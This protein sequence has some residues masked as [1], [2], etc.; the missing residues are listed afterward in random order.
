MWYTESQCIT[1]ILQ[2]KTKKFRDLSKHVGPNTGKFKSQ[3]LDL[4]LSSI[5]IYLLK[6][7]YK[8]LD[9]IWKMIPSSLFSVCSLSFCSSTFSFFLMYGVLLFFSWLL[10]MLNCKCFVKISNGLL[11]RYIFGFQFMVTTLSEIVS[12]SKELNRS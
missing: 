11:Q 6:L 4:D 2:R 8:W 5:K 9:L 1:S 12:I 3:N 10:T 7:F